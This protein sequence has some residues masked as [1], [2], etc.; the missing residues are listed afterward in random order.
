MSPLDTAADAVINLFTPQKK[1]R[2]MPANAQQIEQ[3]FAEMQEA[4]RPYVRQVALASPQQRAEKAIEAIEAEGV[5]TIADLKQLLAEDQSEHDLMAEDV[6]KL[7]EEL[8][9]RTAPLYE[10]IKALMASRKIVRETI[11]HHTNMLKA[12]FN[13]GPK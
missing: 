13:G 2:P 12:P 4:I 6:A 7:E 10:E 1:V 8:N 9:R 3:S 11:A 5:V